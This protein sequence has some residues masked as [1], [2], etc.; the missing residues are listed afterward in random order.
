M[1]HINKFFLILVLLFTSVFKPI[2]ASAK[3][4]EGQALN[5]YLDK[6]TKENFQKYKL[7]SLCMIVVKDGKIIYKNALGYADVKNKIKADVNS[8]VYRIGSTSK[9]F[10]ETA[11]MQLYEQGKIRFKRRC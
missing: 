7:P 2:N 3:I 4:V 5:S 1:K 6:I 8:S 9:L 11:I 10:T